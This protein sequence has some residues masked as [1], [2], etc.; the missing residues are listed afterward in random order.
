ME[1]DAKKQEQRILKKAAIFVLLLSTVACVLLP[2]FP[3]LGIV[4]EEMLEEIK[5]YRTKTKA[6]RLNMTELELLEYNNEQAKEEYGGKLPFSNQLRLELPLGV[7]GKD[8]EITQDYVTQRTRI[9][10]PYAGKEYLYEYP[11]LGSSDH[12]ESL[13]YESSQ[14]YG[15]IE[16]VTDLVY[17]LKTD[18]DEDYLYLDFL[19]P[20][21]LY[22]KVV[23]IDAGHGGNEA[24]TIKQGI[25]EKDI[26]LDIALKL[27]EIFEGVAE[28]SIGVYY[29]RTI[30][31]NPSPKERAVMANKLDADLF[32]S[33]HNNSTKSGRMSSINGTQ[34]FYYEEKEE[35]AISSKGLAEICLEEV[36]A[37]TKSSNK[38]L[39]MGNERD[40][41]KNSK[42]PMA[43]IEVGFMTNQA[44]LD[45][46]C[47]PEYQQKVAR[48]IYNAI[49]RA[50][51]EGY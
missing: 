48:G 32:I 41:I 31:E 21:E 12:M 50:F 43:W 11:I 26:N 39:V 8:L 29:T 10:I 17:E 42:V 36:T 22:D 18:F 49:M 3:R 35:K 45:K 5:E 19:T 4:T 9:Q 2:Y 14:T 44:E 13:T 1:S 20:Q 6:E 24:G 33:I 40:M 34:V 51:E 30:D 16:I 25:Y 38:G 47:M 28:Q 15:I 7:T 46:L 27:K 37:L 23:V